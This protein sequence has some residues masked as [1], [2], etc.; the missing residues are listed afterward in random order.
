M[1]FQ[2]LL[3]AEIDYQ[4][5]LKG[6]QFVIKILVP[7]ILVAVDLRFRFN[8]QRNFSKFFEWNEFF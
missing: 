6:A 3:G 2:Y 1:G 8:S 7:L 4:E 5:D